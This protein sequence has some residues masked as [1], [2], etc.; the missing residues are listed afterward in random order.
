MG[1]ALKFRQSS[2]PRQTGEIARLKVVQGP[3]SGVVYVLLNGNATIGRGDENDVVIYDL[4]ASRKHVEVKVDGQNGWI[5]KDLGSA[6]GVIHNG[7]TVREGRLKNQDT[8]TIGE[9][10][11]EFFAASESVSRMLQAPP[12]EAVQIRAEQ[13]AFESQRNRVLALA[14]AQKGP[15][16]APAAAQITSFA[17]NSIMQ[18]PVVKIAILGA[19]VFLA[20]PLL[21]DKKAVKSQKTKKSSAEDRDLANFLPESNNPITNKSAETFFQAGLREFRERNYLRAKLQFETA[22][23]ISPGYPLAKRYL[24]ES[25]KSIKDEVEAHLTVGKKSMDSGKVKTAKGHFEAVMRLLYRDQENPDYKEAKEQ[26][27]RL[28]KLGRGEAPQS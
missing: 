16:K 26:L 10:M 5:F 25:D 3:E 18:K 8:L 2:V 21:M 9:T 27:D 15:A 19:A 20:F 22:L 7:H 14:G 23:Q 24:I 1:A 11:F 6:N 4:K 13:A 17:T 12:R 28:N